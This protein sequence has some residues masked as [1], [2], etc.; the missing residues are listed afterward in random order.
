MKAIRLLGFPLF[1]SLFLVSIVPFQSCEPEEED[2]ICDTCEICDTCLVVYKPNIYIYPEAK[3]QL[4]V[5]L[6][7]PL[8]GIIVKSIPEYGRG[9]DINVDTNGRINDKY[10]YLFYESKQ[11]DVWQENEGWI[12]KRADLTKFFNEN[13][14][15]YGFRGNEILDFTDY[16][17]PRL[18]GSDLYAI[19]PQDA[20]IINKVIELKFSKEPNEIL[21]LFYV[22]K[23]VNVLNNII[24]EE[25]GSAKLFERNGYFVTEWGVILK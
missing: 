17:I 2:S 24:L 1:V 23:E 21:R 6:I 22:I 14:N 7:F 10:N 9:W 18:S 12:I 13:M 20:T 25:P 15:G 16:W 4:I 5:N 3:S 8:G 19:Y 11:P